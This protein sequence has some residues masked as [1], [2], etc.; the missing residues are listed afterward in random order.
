M[1]SNELVHYVCAYEFETADA[2]REQKGDQK[3]GIRSDR[4]LDSFFFQLTHF[5]YTF[6]NTYQQNMAG[7]SPRNSAS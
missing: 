3:P 7:K 4:R 2:G 5:S 1:D 6:E